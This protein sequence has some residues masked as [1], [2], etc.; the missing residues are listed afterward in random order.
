MSHQLKE[1][2]ST[3][4]EGFYRELHLGRN[5][6]PADRF[7]LEGLLEAAQIGNILS[8][9]EIYELIESEYERFFQQKLDQVFGE[10][11]KD[12]ASFP[13]IPVRGSR[14]PVFPSE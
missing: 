1:L 4:L 10:N 8:I 9:N 13:S 12:S 7:R 6:S 14:A 11:W 5:P 3:R 2:V